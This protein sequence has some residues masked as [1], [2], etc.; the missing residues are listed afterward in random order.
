VLRPPRER[1]LAVMVLSTIG[2]HP[3]RPEAELR[4]RDSICVEGFHDQLPK[5]AAVADD[6]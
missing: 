1:P 5:S 6:V 2:W 3:E 4:N